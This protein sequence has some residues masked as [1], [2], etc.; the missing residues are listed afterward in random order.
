MSKHKKRKHKRVA[1]PHDDYMQKRHA[2]WA[3]CAKKG[4]LTEEQAHTCDELEMFV[5]A[6]IVFSDISPKDI[7]MFERAWS[8]RDVFLRFACQPEDDLE[9]SFY[10]HEEERYRAA[11]AR[12]CVT[13]CGLADYRPIPRNTKG[14]PAY[15]ASNV[16]LK[17]ARNGKS[18][19]PRSIRSTGLAIGAPGLCGYAAVLRFHP[20]NRIFAGR[21]E[22]QY[23]VQCCN[24]AHS[25]SPPFLFTLPAKQLF[26]H[27]IFAIRTP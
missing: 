18:P 27:G 15:R 16:L 25:T 2:Y 24:N 22:K 23:L 1:D 17:I 3:A 14:R 6:V 13:F 19:V 20:K 5:S 9:P 12:L 8:F 7:E 10:F 21:I 11:G 4:E 26:S